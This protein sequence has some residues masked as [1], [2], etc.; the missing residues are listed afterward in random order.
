MNL[1]SLIAP[2][3]Y[4]G[5]GKEGIRHA[6]FDCWVRR[7]G[8]EVWLFCTQTMQELPGEGDN[9]PFSPH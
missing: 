3:R 5:D 4:F 9:S 2:I 1:L 7:G 8:H 6:G